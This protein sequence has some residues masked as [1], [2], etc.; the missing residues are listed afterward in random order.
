MGMQHF[1]YEAF[2]QAINL[3]SL[4]ATSQYETEARAGLTSKTIYEMNQYGHG[5]IV[6]GGNI[7]E[8]G[9]LDVDINALE[10]LEIPLMLFS[11]SRGRVY[12]RHYELMNRTDAMPAHIVSALNKKAQ[13]SLARDITTKNFL[14]DLGFED[15]ELSGCPTIFLD[16]IVERLPRLQETDKSQVLI[17]VRNPFLMSIPLT[18]QSRV[19]D[20]IRAI[21]EFLRSENLKDI[22]LLCHDYRDI[23]FAASLPGVDY[24]YT[25]DI[26]VYLAFLRSCALNISYRLHS[27]LPCLAFNRPCIKISYDERAMSLMETIGFGEWNINMADSQDVPGQVMDRYRRLSDLTNLRVD[28]Q[29]RWNQLYST[30]RGAFQRFSAAVLAHRERLKK[31]ET[32]L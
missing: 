8:N 17:S 14:I 4:P 11:L 27:V 13:F 26:Y 18:L 19:Y 10:T 31:S 7:Y 20:D 32:R 5:V 3:I 9:D 30:I 6:G 24:I 29:S 25:G 15:I 28:V 23:S 1:L 2:G 21:I 12:N 16:R 22:R